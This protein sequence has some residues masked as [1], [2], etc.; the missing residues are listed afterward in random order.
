MT[1]S[2]PDSEAVTNPED[3]PETIKA[4]IRTKVGS[5]TLDLYPQVAPKTVA[6]FLNLASTDF[7]AGT[8]FHRVVSGFVIQGGDPLSKDADPSNDGTGGPG[9]VFEDEINPQSLGLSASQIAQLEASGY[10]YDGS[11]ESIPMKAGVIAMA[12]SGPNTNGSQFFIVTEKDQPHLDGRHTVF[13]RVTAGLDV[14]RA[15]QQGEVI[16]AIEVSL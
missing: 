5:I 10:V 3:L 16:Q 12:N 11:L 14:A 2:N 15:I 4:T 8:T 1:N 13:G 7:Y 9:Y 6:N